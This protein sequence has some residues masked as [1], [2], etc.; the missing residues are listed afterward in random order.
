M[1]PIIRHPNL[2]SARPSAKNDLDHTPLV[3]TAEEGHEA[4]VQL[5]LENGADV[6]AE[7]G[8]CYGSTLQAALHDGNENIVHILLEYG[9][10]EDS[11]TLCSPNQSVRSCPIGT[12]YSRSV[13]EGV[14]EGGHYKP[15][16]L[17]IQG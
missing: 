3:W 8:N 14:P 5:L 2:F 12:V 17:G 10:G 9:A 13:A 11:S 15:V 6:N 1:V 7:D 16:Y 4:V